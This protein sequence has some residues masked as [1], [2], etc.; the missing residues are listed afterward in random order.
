MSALVVAAAFLFATVAFYARRLSEAAT[1]TTLESLL[2]LIPRTVM[3]TTK[4]KRTVPPHILEQYS[5]YAPGYV[6]RVYDDAECQAFLSEYYPPRVVRKWRSLE[7]GAHRADLFRY[8]YLYKHGGWYLDIKT[9]LLRPLDEV[10]R[11]TTPSSCSRSV[12]GDGAIFYV[13]ESV[14]RGSLY[15]GILCTP[16]RNPY[17]LSLLNDIAYDPNPPAEYLTYCYAA[18]AT[19]RD[20]YVASS[21]SRTPNSRVLPMRPGPNKLSLSSSSQAR[22]QQHNA[23]SPSVVVLWR[24]RFDISFGVCDGLP[25]RYNRCSVIVD[26]LGRV[27]FKTRDPTYGVEWI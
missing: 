2:D 24:E 10:L 4:D 7:N 3:L 13:V 9:V 20:D 11:L 19:L 26:Q 5:M 8:A 21:S 25:D 14:Y 18:Y 12:C 23:P 16:P 1:Q 27:L 15:N 17:F 22:Q 6:V